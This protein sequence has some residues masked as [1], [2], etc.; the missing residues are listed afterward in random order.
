MNHLHGIPWPVRAHPDDCRLAGFEVWV[1]NNATA[2]VS[3]ALCGGSTT[4]PGAS[5]TVQ[6]DS[7]ATSGQFVFVTIPGDSKVL[8]LCEVEVMAEPSMC[9]D[10]FKYKTQA[11]AT[12]Q[13]TGF[14]RLTLVA[15]NTHR[16]PLGTPSS[17]GPGPTQCTG[18]NETA[19]LVPWRNNATEGTCQTYTST[20]QIRDMPGSSLLSLC[21]TGVCVID[22]GALMILH[23]CRRRV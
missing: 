11:C 19:A 21:G 3:N 13:C 8:T 22:T 20:M 15:C 23:G 17:A 4:N 2:P 10:G 9:Y 12:G 18:C 7:G 1:G 14:Q 5:I 6:C 16:L